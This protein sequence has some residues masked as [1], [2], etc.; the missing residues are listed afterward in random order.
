VNETH[1]GNLNKSKPP[2]PSV[3]EGPKA[4]GKSN[5]PEASLRKG[6]LPK[7]E[8]VRTAKEEKGACN[9]AAKKQYEGSSIPIKR[10]DQ[11][12][13]NTIIDTHGCV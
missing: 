12:L 6:D 13:E 10:N 11:G 2:K 4:T 7:S 3:E 8:A 5:D 9:A 1:T